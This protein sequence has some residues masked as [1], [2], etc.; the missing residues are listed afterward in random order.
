MK[1]WASVEEVLVAESDELSADV[2]ASAAHDVLLVLE[3]E[4][5]ATEADTGLD[6]A[7]NTAD[8]GKVKA[9]AAAGRARMGQAR[10]F[11]VPCVRSGKNEPSEF[12][13][14]WSGLQRS[15]CRCGGQATRPGPWRKAKP[16][17]LI[18][19]HDKR[20]L[21]GVRGW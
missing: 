20:W 19:K 11:I 12:L 10:N 21:F 15:F 5:G 1:D 17:D 7:A 14:F 4:E 16:K 6:R 9:A 13:N 18:G 2:A 8:A 3:D